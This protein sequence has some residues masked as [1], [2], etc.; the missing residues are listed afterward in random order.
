M[1]LNLGHCFLGTE[2]LET[3][4]TSILGRQFLEVFFNINMLALVQ[5]VPHKLVE[6]EGHR[7]EVQPYSTLQQIYVLQSS[8]QNY[9]NEEE[10]DG[11]GRGSGMYEIQKF[12]YTETVPVA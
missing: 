9:C 4:P 8:L 3:L 6:A 7:R 1:C 5:A 11:V 12:R 10:W 2:R